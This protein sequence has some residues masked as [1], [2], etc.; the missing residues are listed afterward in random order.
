MARAMRYLSYF[1]FF[2]G[3]IWIVGGRFVFEAN[4]REV[5]SQIL[6]KVPRKQSYNLED[7]SN[8]TRDSLDDLIFYFPPVYAGSFL[9]LS[10]VIILDIHSRLKRKSN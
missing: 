10:S 1:L 8:I 5:K 3:F 9:I 2:T 4:L 7:V 6:D